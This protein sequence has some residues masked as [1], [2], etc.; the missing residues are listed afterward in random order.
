MISHPLV[1]RSKVFIIGLAGHA[2]AGKDMAADALVP[3][4]CQ[5]DRPCS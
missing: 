4:N 2:R 3:A 5:S 1:K